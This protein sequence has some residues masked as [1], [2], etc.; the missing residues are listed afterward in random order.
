MHRNNLSSRLVGHVRSLLSAQTNNS[1]NLG[2]SLPLFG[3]R[4]M[5]FFLS[6]LFYS[7]MNFIAYITFDRQDLTNH[8]PPTL[9]LIILEFS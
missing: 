7:I 3:G 8:S 6:S 4:K 5:I 1:E 2:G 9:I